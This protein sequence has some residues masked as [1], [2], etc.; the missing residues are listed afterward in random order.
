M[1]QFIITPWKYD[2][3]LLQVRREIFQLGDFAPPVDRRRHAVDWIAAWKMR[4]NLPHAVQS[5]AHLV[6]AI[7]HHDSSKNSAFSIRATYAAAFSRYEISR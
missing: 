1:P 7:L 3:E 4:G 5:T 2:S 6:D